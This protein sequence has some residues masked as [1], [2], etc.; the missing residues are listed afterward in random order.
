MP[1]RSYP[2]VFAGCVFICGFVHALPAPKDLSEAEKRNPAARPTPTPT[3]VRYYVPAGTTTYAPATARTTTS[4]P[5]TTTSRTTYAAAPTTTTRTT[6]TNVSSQNRPSTTVVIDPGH[7]GFDRGGISGQRVSEKMMNLDVALRLRSIL[8]AYGYRVVMTR[9]TDVFIPLGTRVAMGN[10]YRDGIFVCIHFNAAP[11]GSASGVE[12]Y[13]YTQQS[14]PLASA[15]HYYVAGGAPTQNRGVRRRGFFVLRRTIIPS[16]LVECG[17]LTNP[18]EAQYVQSAGY[19]QKLAEEIAR[20]IRNRSSVVSRTAQVATNTEAVPLQPF[21][22]QTHVHDPDL[23]RSKHSS[24]RGL[25][26]KSARSKKS[27]NDS[28]SDSDNVT[29][30]KKKHSSTSSDDDSKPRKKKPKKTED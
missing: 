22:D 20:G 14:L 27:S 16:V 10:S 13:F 3:P 19:R 21:I 15:I 26:V 29:P 2:L 30:K 23:T 18:T 1:K 28:S 5:A 11:R 17:F 6:T 25:K 24:K 12:T 9:D 7:G 8:Q 4:A